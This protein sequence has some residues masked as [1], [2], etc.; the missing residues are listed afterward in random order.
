MRGAVVCRGPREATRDIQSR[1][2]VE[3]ALGIAGHSP[4][5][6]SPNS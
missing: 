3:G 5:P 2:D 4:V 6:I 1:D